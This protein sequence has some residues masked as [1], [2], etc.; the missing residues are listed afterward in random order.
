[1]HNTPKGL[2]LHIGI[3]GRRNSG[4]SSLIN[5]LTYQDVS[6][7]SEV[8]GTT[9]DPVE[10]PMEFLP[11][12]PVVFID[13]AG[14]DDVGALGKKRIKK[15]L[16]V[17]D[18][19]NIALLVN[20]S[21]LWNEFEESLLEVF[22][23]KQI[24]VIVVFNKSD[25]NLPNAKV[26]RKLASAGIKS[27]RTSISKK[28]GI[29]DL[30]NILVNSVPE[31]FIKSPQII[32][33]LV[34]PK[35][36]VVLVIPIDKEAPKGRIILPQVQT[37]REL[38]DNGVMSVV[39]RETELEAAL[40]SLNQPPSLV[41]TD[42]Q[43][44]AEVSKIVP[45]KIL[46]TSFSILYSR[47]KGDLKA[48]IK[49]AKSIKYLKPDDKILIS[50]SCAHHPIGEDIGRV[51]IP[52]WLEEYVGGELNFT[53]IQGHDFPDNIREYKL[54]IQCGSCVSNR[55]ETLR[56]VGQCKAAKV[57]ITNYGLAIA[58]LKG[59]LDRATKIFSVTS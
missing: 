36:V 17:I 16:Q 58:F 1:M 57:H 8:P 24:P 45:E 49:G 14:L 28:E 34:E 4:K 56:K 46:L 19:V 55:Q 32:G 11:I 26:E 7:V 39:T 15:S 25:I 48:F 2:R 6:I 54:V 42:S 10:K 51:K 31:K 50:E 22:K 41:V 35:D 44:F 59:I 30:R 13:T 5:A 21:D 3:F 40:K 29:V 52:K 33:D 27:V 37:L 38:L 23:N 12:G 18:R 47:C 53:T 9:T 43:A 20:D